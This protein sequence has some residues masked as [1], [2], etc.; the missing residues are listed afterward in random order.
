MLERQCIELSEGQVTQSRSESSSTPVA[1]A[2]PPS[3]CFSRVVL[4]AGKRPMPNTQGAVVVAQL[5]GGCDV[6]AK[7]LAAAASDAVALVLVADKALDDPSCWA[8]STPDLHACWGISAADAPLPLPTVV[9]ADDDGSWWGTVQTWGTRDTAQLPH[10]TL[11]APVAPLVPAKPSSAE[12]V[13]HFW[14]FLGCLSR[15]P[16]Q[17]TLTHTR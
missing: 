2:A 17:L 7:A 6:A 14:Y 15:R 4:K 5:G 10:A 13:L 8:S 11:E 12:Q 3:A 16:Q 9:V 1:L